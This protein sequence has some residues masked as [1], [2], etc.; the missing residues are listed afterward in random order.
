MRAVVTCLS[1]LTTEE[2]PHAQWIVNSLLDTARTDY[3][4]RQHLNRIL[5][6]WRESSYAPVQKAGIQESWLAGSK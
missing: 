5:D 1:L 6:L 4:A 2:D 3:K